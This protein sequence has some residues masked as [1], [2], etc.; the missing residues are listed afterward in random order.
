[1][2]SPG[3]G[4]AAAARHR[5]AWGPPA[6]RD[7]APGS[8]RNRSST[9]AIEAAGS[10]LSCASFG[11]LSGCA[12]PGFS[13]GVQALVSQQR[14]GTR[15]SV[16]WPAPAGST[17]TLAAC[18]RALEFGEQAGDAVVDKAPGFDQ[19]VGERLG[20]LSNPL[21]GQPGLLFGVGGNS[22]WGSIL[23]PVFQPPEQVITALQA[24]G[25][26]GVVVPS[27][28]SPCSASMVT[29]VCR[30]MPAAQSCWALTKN[31]ISRMPPR[32]SLR[33]KPAVCSMGLVRRSPARSGCSARMR[34][35]RWAT[36]STEKSRCRRRGR[37]AGSRAASHPLRSP[38]TTRAL[39]FASRR[40]RRRQKWT[41]RPRS[42]KGHH[43]QVWPQPPVG[44][45]DEP[46]RPCP[47]TVWRSA[48]PAR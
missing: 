27:S 40:R 36:S 24:S 47:S 30:R 11:I 22:V 17:V 10:S 42:T 18:T 48:A 43:R 45:P 19:R 4:T 20:Q 31:S 34:V 26:F 12:C 8:R 44:A 32:P 25:E 6:T 9:C 5:T 23:H 15:P 14:V 28:A 2:P 29:G 41:R 38:A 7:A 13:A 33:L 37:D 3:R 46:S 35:L 1:M 21:L 16:D 39:I